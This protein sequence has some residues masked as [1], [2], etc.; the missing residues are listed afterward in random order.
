MLVLELGTLEIKELRILPFYYLHYYDKVSK[1]IQ[2]HSLA[3][4]PTGVRVL[5]YYS[6]L[7]P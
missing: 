3:K 2:P 7:R 4:T 1:I 5:C 6:D